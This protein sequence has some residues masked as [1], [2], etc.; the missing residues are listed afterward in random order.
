MHEI[1]LPTMLAWLIGSGILY[2]GISW[3]I[4]KYQLKQYSADLQ[5][6]TKGLKCMEKRL[7]KDEQSYMTR[8]DCRQQQEDCGNHRTYHENNLVEKMADLKT[9]M[10]EMDKRRED[11]R[12][13]LK[14]A[15]GQ[16][17]NEL[18]ELKTQMAGLP[19]RE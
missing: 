2:A 10:V 7:T 6:M 3:G 13:E 5:E 15:L 16:I 4:V 17:S 19:Q 8:T 11:T 14:T 18:G 1:T 12:N 9:L